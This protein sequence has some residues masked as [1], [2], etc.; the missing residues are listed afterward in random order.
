MTDKIYR[1]FLGQELTIGDR[2]IINNVGGCQGFDW[3][4]VHSFT[5][6]MV[7][8]QVGER[9]TWWVKN[10]NIILLQKY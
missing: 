7:R 1:D 6:K 9:K 2:V 10:K 8:V 3:G 5:P 4:T